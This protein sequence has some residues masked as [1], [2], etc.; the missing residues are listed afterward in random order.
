MAIIGF[1][2]AFIF[3][4]WIMVGVPIVFLLLT[5]LSNE[6]PRWAVLPFAIGCVLMYLTLTHSPFH[7]AV[8]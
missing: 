6:S 5:G 2:V 8:S 3:S 4:L 7:I 1:I